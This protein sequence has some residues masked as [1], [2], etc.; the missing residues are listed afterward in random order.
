MRAFLAIL[1]LCLPGAAGAAGRLDDAWCAP[2]DTI[3]QALATR[4]G[5]VKQGQGVRDPD[6]LMELWANGDGGWT[7]VVTYADGHACVVG[8]GEAWDMSEKAPS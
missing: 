1:L 5:A 6:S 4:D 7:L 2:R 3:T 8:Q